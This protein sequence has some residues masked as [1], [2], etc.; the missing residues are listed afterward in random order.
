MDNKD[1]TFELRK[2]YLKNK[3]SSISVGDLAKQLYEYKNENFK[4]LAT[5]WQWIV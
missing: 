1:D 3:I 5:C 2:D 4:N